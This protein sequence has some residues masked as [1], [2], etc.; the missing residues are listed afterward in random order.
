LVNLWGFGPQ[1]AGAIPDAAAIAAAQARLGL[2]ALH[3]DRSAGTVTFDKA[4]TLDLSGIAKGYA[5]DAVA[6]LLQD[7]G[8]A[9][10]LVEIGGELRLQ[11][12]RPDGRSWIVAVERP[13]GGMPEA[14]TRLD[15]HGKAAGLA[16]SGDY[17][18][19]REVDGRRYS[20]EIDPRTG[21]PVAHTLASVT[22]LATTA[23]AADAWATALMVLGPDEGRAVA[24][25]EGLAAYFI[26]RGPN[27]FEPAYTA[28]FARYLQQPD[29]PSH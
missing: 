16:G 6:G 15:L 1:P 26:L 17:R 29:P 9:S 25:S 24:D 10:F 14:F 23:A 19:Y 3:I 8:F 11:G 13:Q 22:V 20:H 27:G 18:N 28:A 4:L 2:N 12:A 5:V 7:L 21:R